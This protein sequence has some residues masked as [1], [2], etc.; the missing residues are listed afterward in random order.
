MKLYSNTELLAS[1]KIETVTIHISEIKHYQTTSPLS[2]YT[3]VVHV[4]SFSLN[5]VTIKFVKGFTYSL[6]HVYLDNEKSYE[7]KI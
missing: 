1:H 4:P 2:T 7:W 6:Y 3:C 5:R